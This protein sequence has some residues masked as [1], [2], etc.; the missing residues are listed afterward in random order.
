MFLKQIKKGKRA[1][2]SHKFNSKVS[3]MFSS[4]KK[5]KRYVHALVLTISLPFTNY[6]IK[7]NINWSLPANIIV[8]KILEFIL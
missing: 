5:A 6:N 3:K 1:Y 7:E 2:D 4:H 8:K